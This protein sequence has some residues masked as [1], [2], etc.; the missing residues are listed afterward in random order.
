LSAHASPTIEVVRGR[1]DRRRADELLS[2]WAERGAL[3]GDEAR[4]RL[5][6][7]VCVLRLDGALAGACSVYPADVALIGSRRF[8]VYRSLLDDNAIG[9]THEMIRATFEVL[10]GEFSG[11]VGEPIGLCVLVDAAERRLRP[12]LVWAD[13]ALLYAGYLPDGRQVRVAYF[14]DARI[15]AATDS[16]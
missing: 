16:P 9:Q 1:L 4:R 5:P 8:W 7:V 3:P 2:F 13:P 11:S 15:D 10:E 14:K 12:E 6:E